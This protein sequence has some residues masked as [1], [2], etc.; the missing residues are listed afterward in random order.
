MTGRSG[1]IPH[2]GTRD[3]LGNP[4]QGLN[5]VDVHEEMG[6]G[7]AIAKMGQVPLSLHIARHQ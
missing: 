2:I 4:L 1:A 7:N 5:Q 6:V 3:F